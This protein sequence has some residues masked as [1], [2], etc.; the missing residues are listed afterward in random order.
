M[1]FSIGK[2]RLDLLCPKVMGILNITPDSFSDGGSYYNFEQASQHAEKMISAGADIID[3][4]GESTR[5]GA[6]PVTE[7]EELDRVIPVLEYLAKRFNTL[8]SVDTSKP[9]VMLEA[10]KAG[11]HMINDVFALRKPGAL[12][13]A[14][15]T[16]LPIC[17]MHMQGHPEN[18]QQSPRYED[19]LSE[20]NAFFEENIE[21]CLSVGIPKNKLLI[22]PGFGFGKSLTHNY[23]LLA[24][25]EKFQHFHLPMLVGMSR[26]SMID[27]RPGIL[28]KEKV[29]GSIACAVIAAMKGAHIIRVHDVKETVEALHIVNRTKTQIIKNE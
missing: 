2:H 10:K 17:L 18:M 15:E 23:Q 7:Q 24:N 1:D 19:V 3:I 20:V 26:K 28:P 25:L 12:E 11:A 14:A 5:P 13:A 4:G 22:D 16:E 9:A 27:G 8:L 21:R 6:I 29:I